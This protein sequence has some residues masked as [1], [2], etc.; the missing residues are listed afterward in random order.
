MANDLTLRRVGAELLKAI[1]A[2]GNIVGP[3]ALAI[4]YQKAYSFW[5]PRPP[6]GG[7]VLRTRRPGASKNLFAPRQLLTESGQL[8]GAASALYYIPSIP[9]TEEY[10]PLD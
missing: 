3:A 10:D 4:V 9:K 7:S 8:N 2:N 1:D 6:D 5:T